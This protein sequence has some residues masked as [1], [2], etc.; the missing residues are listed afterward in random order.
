M[1]Q[2]GHFIFVLFLLKFMTSVKSWKKKKSE[3]PRLEDIL[4]DMGLVFLK[5]LT[6]MKI[7][8]DWEIVIDRRGQRKY[9]NPMQRGALDWILEQREDV[10]EKTWQNPNEADIVENGFTVGLVLFLLTKT[11]SLWRIGGMSYISLPISFTLHTLFSHQAHNKN[12]L[13]PLQ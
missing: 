10:T 7:E 11:S 4:Q 5:M 9:N 6:V 1:W 13:T 2:E 12:I 8:K 3:R